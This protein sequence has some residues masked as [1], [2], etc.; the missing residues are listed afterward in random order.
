MKLTVI[1]WDLLCCVHVVCCES[2]GCIRG[3]R[4]SN[5]IV[6]G[7]ASGPTSHP[8]GILLISSVISP[9]L[10]ILYQYAIVKSFEVGE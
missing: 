6:A 7:R 2:T 9:W 1:A 3:G 8:L 5:T 10:V 4:V